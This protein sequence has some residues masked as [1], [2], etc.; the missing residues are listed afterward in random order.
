[1]NKS[2]YSGLVIALIGL[3][4]I[5][6]GF[7]VG[8]KDLR[9]NSL[10]PSAINSLEADWGNQNSN[11]DNPLN[12]SEAGSINAGSDLADASSDLAEASSYF[13]EASSYFAEAGDG[14]VRPG[15]A[16]TAVYLPMLRGQNVGFVGNNSSRIG[17]QHDIEFLLANGVTI[18]TLFAPEHGFRGEEEAG[19]SISNESD[20]ATGLPIISLYGSK[21]KPTAKDLEN[22]DIMLFDIQDVGVRCFTYIS[23]LHYI[24]EACAENKIPLIVADRPNPNSYYIDGPTLEEGFESFVGM[25]PVPL[26]YGMTIGEYS[27]MINGEGWLQGSQAQR[28]KQNGEQSDGLIAGQGRQEVESQRAKQ[29][30]EQSENR[31]K[32]QDNAQI[33][34]QDAG[35]IGLRCELIVIPIKGWNHSMHVYP[36]T[37]PSPNLPDSISITLYPSL[38]LFEG[39]LIS[40]GRG[41]EHPFQ[42]FGH[43]ML[44]NMDYSFTP[45]PIKGK[46]L[47][48]KC[49]GELCHGE[50]LTDRYDEIIKDGKIHLEWLIEA[51]RNYHG[52]APFFNDFFNRLAGCSSLRRDIE[53]NKS[54]AEI[55]SS[56]Q[57]A[58]SLFQTLRSRYL[59]YP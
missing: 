9:E 45:M 20:P 39:T 24:M 18:T 5:I 57:P 4:L 37:A 11:T 13:A 58:L 15:I 29:K 7:R 35:E 34:Q 12:G 17:A 56:W 51:Y 53:D 2:R 38:V 41:T 21:K 23:T 52:E 8:T 3:L 44:E 48:P 19:E 55:R 30:G 10:N 16:D 50:L 46:S 32:Q 43:P 6:V 47:D 22:I 36:E 1:M 25:D 54:E 31:E 28:A 26:V 40:E 49:K 14:A 27:L 42:C 33:A 59:L